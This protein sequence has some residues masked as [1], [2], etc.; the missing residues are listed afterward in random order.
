MMGA[1]TNSTTLHKK[2]I[3]KKYTK[4]PT[5]YLSLASRAR[6]IFLFFSFFAYFLN[7]HNDISCFY[8]QKNKID[9]S[10]KLIINQLQFLNFK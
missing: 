8:R 1:K 6:T 10:L 4:M 7:V 3:G 2:K 5:N 9:F